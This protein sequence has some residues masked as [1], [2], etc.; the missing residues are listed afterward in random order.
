VPFAWG[1]SEPSVTVW[2]LVSGQVG[3]PF[4]LD[5]YRANGALYGRTEMAVEPID[6]AWGQGWH[7]RTLS[8][9]LDGAI[10]A[11]DYGEWRAELRA[12]GLTMAVRPF[13]VGETSRFAPRFRPVAGKSF[14]LSSQTQRD[15]LSISRLGAPLV[16]LTFALEGAPGNVS[17]LTGSAG[18]RSSRSV[19]G[20]GPRGSSFSRVFGR[21]DRS[22]WRARLDALSVGQLRG[23]TL[24]S[25]P[26][27]LAPATASAFE[28]KR[29]PSMF[30]LPMV[31]E[32]A[33]R[34]DRRSLQLSSGTDA[35]FVADS[36]T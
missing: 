24:G 26:A 31:T 10:S 28:E 7:Y 29:Y 12:G 21:R 8:F 33:W 18:R 9:A 27:V 6:R 36:V 22:R 5:V 13:T 19:R 20:A 25:P 35:S 14:H 32:I 16:D 3:D 11:A 1:I 23:G 4:W 34:P 30:G 15:T 17:L 2:A